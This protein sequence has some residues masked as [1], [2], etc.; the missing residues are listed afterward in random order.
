MSDFFPVRF[1]VVIP[2]FQREAGILSKCLQS[3][4]QQTVL[5]AIKEIII[6]DDGSPVSAEAEVSCLRA[7]FPATVDVK[8]ICQANAG[9][10]AAR[11]KALD[12]VSQQSTHIAYLD[13][14]DTWL[15][16]HL[17]Y[18]LKAIALGAR[19]FFSNHLQLNSAVPAFARASVVAH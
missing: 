16:E 18:A 2:F 6:V 8:V 19:F 11:N 17:E 10:S 5:G 1:A 7:A 13:S 3:I 15:P 9:V 14:D 4:A 12:S